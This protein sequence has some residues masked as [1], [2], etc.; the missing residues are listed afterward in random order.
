MSFITA[1]ALI[2]LSAPA[3]VTCEG[4]YDGHLQGIASD[5]AGNIYWSF[6]VSLVK[7]DDTGKILKKID[8]PR[9][10]GDLCQADGMVYVAVNLG[11]FNK[12]AGSADSWIYAYNADD[13]ALAWKKPIPE[14]VHGAGGMDTR[15]GHYFVVGG[16]PS[17]HEQNYVYEYDEN[18]RFV[19]RHE[20]DS[21]QTFLGIQ[22]ACFAQGA[23]WFGCYGN[24]PELLKTDENFKLLA[25]TPFD[26]A[27]GVMQ[28]DDDTLRV[29]RHV[30]LQDGKHGG[31]IV[32]ARPT[33]AN[34]LEIVE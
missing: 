3:A 29:G 25:R 17:T 13:L 24:P 9:H 18:A 22:T 14:A 5:S 16:L 7:T 10:H 19:A 33:D 21:G 34:G 31:Q 11:E 4:R 32:T 1:V 30:P 2:A 12:E 27:I 8:V 20:I 23:W 15:D 6:T 26:C 28:G